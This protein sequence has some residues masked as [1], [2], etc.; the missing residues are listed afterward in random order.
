MRTASTVA[1]APLS[2]NIA[3]SVSFR[4][5]PSPLTPA[6]PCE[7]RFRHLPSNIDH[8]DCRK[9]ANDEHQAPSFGPRVGLDEQPKTGSQKEPEAVSGLHETKRFGPSRSRPCL[10]NE[11]RACAPFSSE[12]HAGEES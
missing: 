6:A 12:K 3:T 11:G 4:A 2:S 7:L 1:K 5:G 10:R 9:Y 8:Q